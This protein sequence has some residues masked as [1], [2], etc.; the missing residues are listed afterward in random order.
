MKTP[1]YILVASLL[2]FGS[3]AADGA[4][5][6]RGIDVVVSKNGRVAYQ[7][8]TDGS[9]AFAT[10]PLDSGAYVVEFRSSKVAGNKLSLTATGG[11]KKVIADSVPGEKFGT[12]GVAMKVDV[13]ASSKLSGQVS[14]G[15]LPKQ[16]A[17]APAGENVEPVKANVK[18]IN[19]KRHV[20][21][22]GPIGSGMGG[23]W[24]EEGS[25]A[26]ALSTSNKKGGDAEM[27][28]RLQDADSGAA[29]LNHRNTPETPDTGRG[30]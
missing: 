6:V 30:P 11:K 21:V 26:A 27:L 10:G 25:E 29:T 16:V 1:R 15:P 12:G 24:V 22:P 7:G 9:G 14:V 20:W 18:I 2:L 23:R 5:S 19:G 4:P 17:A 28:R 13:A 3:T 8:K